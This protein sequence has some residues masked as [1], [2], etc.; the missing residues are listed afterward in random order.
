M[1][2]SIKSIISLYPSLALSIVSCTI[3][4]VRPLSFVSSWIAVI[5]SLVPATLKSISPVKSSVAIRS[6]STICLVT[7]PFSSVSVIS[8][9]AIPATG[10]LSGTPASIRARV[11]PHTDP[12]LVE[13]PEPRHSETTLIEYG[14]SSLLG[15]IFSRAF[16]ANLPCQISLLPVPLIAFASPVEN[17]GKL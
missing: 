12:I 8:P 7:A 15:I 17:G 10:F 6:L 14:N 2:S 3:S 11:E 1:V 5:P 16:S 4:K 13:P 9:I